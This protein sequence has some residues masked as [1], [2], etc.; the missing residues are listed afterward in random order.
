MALVSASPLP[1]RMLLPGLCAIE[2]P[3]SPEPSH[4]VFVEPHAVR[5]R[6]WRSEHAE[7]RW[8]LAEAC[9]I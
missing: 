8:S 6:K 7:A 5:D 1:S 3:W 2:A 4:V 9:A